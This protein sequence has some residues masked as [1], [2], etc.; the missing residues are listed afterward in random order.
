MRD[1]T[2]MKVYVILH[3]IRS[4]HNVG[5][6]FRTADGAG[7]TKIFL[8]GYTP[9]PQ[10]SF[11]RVQNDIAK[12]ALGAEKTVPWEHCARPDSFFKKARKEGWNIVAVEQDARS[13][14]FTKFKRSKK[15]LFVVGNE[16]KG[17]P[18]LCIQRCDG[19]VEI[20]MHGKKESLN[21]S[22]AAGIILFATR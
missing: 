20:P 21:V 5:S 10:D 19:V 16:V 14:P 12:T 22:V 6:L 11:G 4:A 13:I 1:I 15:T 7:V 9:R 8:I 2:S 18:R 17:I 3:N